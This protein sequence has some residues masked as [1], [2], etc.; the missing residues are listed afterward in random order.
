MGKVYYPTKA[1]FN[2]LPEFYSALSYSVVYK[3]GRFHLFYIVKRSLIAYEI[4]HF[5]SESAYEWE[6][7]GVVNTSKLPIESITGYAKNGKIYLLYTVRSLPFMGSD[8]Y[9]AVAKDDENFIVFP[10]PIIKNSKLNDIKTFYYQGLRYVIGSE[11]KDG[12][13][14][15][16][17]SD[18]DTEWIESNIGVEREGW[19]NIL[20]GVIAE[21][22]VFGAMGAT[23]LLNTACNG[24]V[25]SKC[26]L[27]LEA[28]VIKVHEAL[29]ESEADNARSVMVGEGRPIIFEKS[30]GVLYPIEVFGK[31]DG[32]GFRFYRETLK[33]AKPVA[34][35]ELFFAEGGLKSYDNMPL[36]YHRVN[37]PQEGGKVQISIGNQSI[38]I[39]EE[40]IFIAYEDIS[41]VVIDRPQGEV[42]IGILQATRDL[43]IVEINDNVYPVF[44]IG[45]ETLDIAFTEE[46]KVEY[47]GYSL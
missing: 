19:I 7:I 9:L 29:R 38:L 8:L 36:T 34:E 15:I 16:A 4:M 20:N 33:T 17:C 42:E 11:I 44:H 3:D 5:A 41:E 24:V 13:M 28:G 12:I 30:G 25:I 14:P 40:A 39:D 31:E 2:E 23:Y 27:D 43:I 18:S 46:V 1:Y 26:E 32:L 22:S 6:F 45:G 35:E 37:L 21:P 10:N 47:R